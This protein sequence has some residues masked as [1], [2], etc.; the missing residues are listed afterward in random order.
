MLTARAV[1]TS[2]V[3]S[4]LTLHRSSGPCS[5]LERWTRWLKKTNFASSSFLSLLH[6]KLCLILS[7]PNFLW[8]WLPIS[9]I[10][11]CLLLYHSLIPFDCIFK[12]I[13]WWWSLFH[14]TLLPLCFLQFTHRLQSIFLAALDVTHAAFEREVWELVI[15]FSW[16]HHN[17]TTFAF[18]FH[19]IWPSQGLINQAIHYGPEIQA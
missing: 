5:P 11:T 10:L 16:S 8:S 9:W 3:R 13:W 18:P 2:E 6:F 19:K 4:S 12:E 7:S 15:S 14:A 1:N 17:Q